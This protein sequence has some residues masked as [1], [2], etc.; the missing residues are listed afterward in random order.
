MKFRDLPP[1]TLFRFSEVGLPPR[2]AKAVAGGTFRKLAE[3]GAGDLADPRNAK[4]YIPP[5][6]NV[7]RVPMPAPPGPPPAERPPPAP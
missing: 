6:T 1:G 5:A 4:V 7:V 3:D 2:F